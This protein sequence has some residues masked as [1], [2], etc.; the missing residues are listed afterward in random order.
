MSK[1]S[2]VAKVREAMVDAQRKI[3]SQGGVVMD[4]RDIGTVVFPKADTKIFL[5]ASVEERAKRRFLE[6]KNKGENVDI[7]KLQEDIAL[8]DKLDSEREV[9]PLRCAEDAIYL[10]TSKMSITDVVNK[11]ME[12]SKESK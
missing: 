5:T 9:S 2:A 1:V 12:I 8:R 7:K 11:I 6:L 4:G 3:G 10:D